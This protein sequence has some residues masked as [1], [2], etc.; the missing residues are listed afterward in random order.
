M[1]MEIKITINPGW[2]TEDR[3]N[4]SIIGLRLFIVFE[5]RKDKEETIPFR[6]IRNA[7]NSPT[8]V[9]VTVIREDNAID[10]REPNERRERTSLP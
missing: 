5:K 2:N 10:I 6:S 1:E 7:I 8:I 4:A 3:N 9:V